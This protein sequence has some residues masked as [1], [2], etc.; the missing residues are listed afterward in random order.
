MENSINHIPDINEGRLT[1]M[2]WSWAAIMLMLCCLSDTLLLFIIIVH[3][4]IFT[5]VL[6]NRDI[7]TYITTIKK[8]EKKELIIIQNNAYEAELAAKKP[9]WISQFIVYNFK[10]TTTNNDIQ[11]THK[12]STH[13]EKVWDDTM[14]ESI[15][16]GANTIE[17]DVLPSLSKSDSSR[18]SAL[19]FEVD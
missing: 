12:I 14:Q 2:R 9:S 13:I 8:E 19:V 16:N 1:A 18:R 15:E 3:A 11:P 5:I 6:L 4:V 7:S 10:N 17:F